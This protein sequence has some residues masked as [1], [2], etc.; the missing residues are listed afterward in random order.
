MRGP[1]LHSSCALAAA[2]LVLLSGCA[3]DRAAQPAVAATP[4]KATV[5]PTMCADADLDGV[6]D[7]DDRC[8]MTPSN[9]TVDANGCPAPAVARVQPVPVPAPAP[10]PVDRV[11]LSAHALFDDD[12]STLLPA[13]APEIERLAAQLKARP[14]ATVL[15]EGHTD[16]RGAA[17][18][19]QRLSL[20]RANAVRDELVE[21][22]GIA[23]SRIRA[24]GLGAQQPVAGNATADGRALNRRV[25]ARIQESNGA[26]P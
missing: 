20:A 9:L 18:H 2:A 21:R 22:Y 5:A 24:V 8:Q 12:Q 17:V 13:S 25:D 6:C 3:T 26:A 7:A 10:E 23:P 1:V 11:T 4:A 14:G 15:I 16:N 19:N